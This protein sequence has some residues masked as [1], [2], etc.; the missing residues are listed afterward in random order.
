MVHYGC[1]SFV[2][3]QEEVD[4]DEYLKSESYQN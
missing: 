3:V 1:T 4:D 2:V